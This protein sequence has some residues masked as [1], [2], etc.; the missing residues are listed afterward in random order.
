MTEQRQELLT[1]LGFR[2]GMNGPH[3]ARTMMLDDLRLLMAHTLTASDTCRIRIGHCRQQCAG[4]ANP[5]RHVN[6]PCAHM[7][8]L[9]A[10][11]PANPIFRAL[12]RLWSLDENAQPMLA[13]AVALARDPL[14]RGTQAFLPWTGRWCLC[15]TGHGGG[16]SQH[17]AP[18]PFQSCLTE[19]ICAK[20]RRHM[21]GSRHL[22]WTCSQDTRRCTVAP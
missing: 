10:L 18:G 7:A 3:A 9:Y 11:D 1:Q 22:A 19:V 21:D 14:L 8:T 16:I 17:N 12:R 20:C 6:W 5:Q 2:F 4:Q 15:P 13:L